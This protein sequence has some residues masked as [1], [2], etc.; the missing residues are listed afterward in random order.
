MF[1]VPIFFIVF[2][3]TLE[4]A[5]IVSVLLGLVEQLVHEDPKL[6]TGNPTP[7]TPEE[8]REGSTEDANQP[9]LLSQEDKDLRAKRLIKKLRIQIFAGSI[10][11]LIVALAIGAAFIA[12]WFTQASDLWSKSEELWEGTRFCLAHAY[13]TNAVMGILGIFELIAAII[14]FVMGVTML[15]MDRAKAKWRVK[16]QRAFEGKRQ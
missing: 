8:K 13:L 5:I 14:I 7:G 15:K 16:L 9:E 3:E 4:A 12:V 6:T 1:S 11:G 10:L 2:R